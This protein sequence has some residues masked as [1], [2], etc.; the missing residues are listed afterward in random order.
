MRMPTPD[1]VNRASNINKDDVFFLTG[2]S[3]G[4]GKIW[5]EELLKRGYRVVATARKNKSIVRFKELFPELVVCLSLDVTS[6]RSIKK[7][8]TE[9]LTKFGKLDVFINNAGIG[10]FGIIEN[11]DIKKAKMIFETNFWGVLN[12]LKMIIPVMRKNKKGLIIQPSSMAS[13]IAPPLASIYAATMTGREALFEALSAEVGGFNIRTLLLE[14][15]EVKT[16]FYKNSFIDK[17]LKEGYNNTYEAILKNLSENI[18]E[19]TAD[20]CVAINSIIDIL[21]TSEQLPF[22]IC[23]GDEAR[24]S[25]NKKISNFESAFPLTLAEDCFRPQSSSSTT[26]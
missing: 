22:R 24:V 26:D 9:A 1:Q 2:C 7:A 4:L 10:Y 20:P 23:I 11:I 13:F 19:S 16:N 5:A 6:P 15:G 21:E 14:F 18:Y 25:L 17:N 8:I 12:T 3:S